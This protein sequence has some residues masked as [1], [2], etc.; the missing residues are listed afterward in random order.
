MFSPSSRVPSQGPIGRAVI[1][2]AAA[3]GA[4]SKRST[5]MARARIGR[6][7]RLRV[8]T[9]RVVGV[10]AERFASLC[11]FLG[12]GT[13]PEA[14]KG[15]SA[16]AVSLKVDG[17]LLLTSMLINSAICLVALS[18]PGATLVPSTP[19]SRFV[20]TLTGVGLGDRV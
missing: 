1:G 16:E 5:N 14:R 4:T 7:T 17:A 19:L 11:L 8:A 9:A 13:S 18:S 6:L 3:A 2:T 20:P 10:F 15:P 12:G